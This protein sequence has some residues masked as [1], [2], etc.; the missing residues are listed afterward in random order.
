MA[1]ASWGS[2]QGRHH[3]RHGVAD[4]AGRRHIDVVGSHGD[5]GAGRHGARVDE[6]VGSGLDVRHQVEDVLGG[7]EP[8][9]GSVHVEYDGRGAVLFGFGDA[10]ADCVDE[11]PLDHAFD[12]YDVGDAGG[13]RFPR[14]GGGVGADGRERCDETNE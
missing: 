6:R 10:S 8:A 3:D 14:R 13:V 1:A 7:V 11:R 2:C 9:A 5:D 4:E 12:G